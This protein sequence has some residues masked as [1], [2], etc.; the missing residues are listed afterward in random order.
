MGKNEE[1]LTALHIAT[2]NQHVKSMELLIKAGASKSAINRSGN[3]PLHL[4]VLNK[5]SKALKMLMRNGADVN[6]QN[7][8][9]NTALHLA[10]D[11]GYRNMVEI[12]LDAEYPVE[13]SP[14][15]V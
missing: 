11:A 6:V 7:H 9:G 12:L 10:T 3:T 5:S 8:E 15:N 4:A 2:D 14:N 1:G 13:L